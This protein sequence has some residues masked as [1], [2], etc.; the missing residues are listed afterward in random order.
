MTIRLRQQHDLIKA[1]FD[2]RLLLAPLPKD[3]PAEVL[4]SATGSGDLK[5]HIL[6]GPRR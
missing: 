5:L 2:G 6:F 3:A 4:D 1:A